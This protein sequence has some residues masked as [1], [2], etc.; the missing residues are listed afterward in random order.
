M[1]ATSGKQTVCI[2]GGAGFIGS[3]V[4]DAF[5]ARG[6]RVLV[7]DSLVGGRRESVPLGAELHVLDIRSPRA[8]ALVREEGV[9]ILLH[10]AAQMDVRRSVEDPLFDAD[11]NVLGS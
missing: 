1:S 2:T 6:D 11:V 3:H 9:D 8:A 4:A 5:I 10:Y 7:I